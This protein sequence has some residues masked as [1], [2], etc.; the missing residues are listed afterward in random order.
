MTKIKNFFLPL[1]VL[2]TLE[3]CLP[4]VFVAGATAGG[5]VIYDSR[6]MK[7][8]AHD[9]DID[10]KARDIINDDVDLKFKSHLS[11]TT[12]NQIAL[13]VGQTPTPDLRDRLIKK[14]QTIPN[15]KRIYNEITIEPPTSSSARS[16]DVWLTTK[17]KTALLA[18]SGLHSSQIKVVTEKSSV[19]LMGVVS[20]S[21]GEIAAQATS[22]VEGIA[23]VVKLFEYVH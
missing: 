15:V 22:K 11:V 3:G 17:V 7:V 13:A 4:A 18:Q 10:T 14:L 19:Y 8:M 1:V 2:F 16:H 6:S 23:K 5:A 9:Q 21:Q 20:K 12:F